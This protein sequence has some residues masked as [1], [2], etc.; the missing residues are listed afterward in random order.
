M[1][2]GF[3]GR[4]PGVVGPKSSRTWPG[5]ALGRHWLP[6]W[7]TRFSMLPRT[8]RLAAG[9][10]FCRRRARRASRPDGLAERG[11]EQGLCNA[12]GPSSLISGRR[13]GSF[14]PGLNL[15]LCLLERRLGIISICSDLNHFRSMIPK[16]DHDST[17]RSGG[18]GLG[19]FINLVSEY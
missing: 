1:A 6:R 14:T 15:N 4:W 3:L 12:K 13:G 16:N 17:D 11:V 9:P 2:A 18:V 8:D 19:F 5:M 10:G 7:S